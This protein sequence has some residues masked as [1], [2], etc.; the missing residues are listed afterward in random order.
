MMLAM[1]A[2][3]RPVAGQATPSPSPAG[4]SVIASGEG[5]VKRTPDRAWVQI[6]AESRARNPREA[7]K[8]NVDTMSLV[9]QK[10]RGTGLPPDA[11]QTRGYDL[12]PEF[13][14]HN[15]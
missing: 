14:Y 7:Q 10:L 1:L 5:L 12:Q 11:I 6:T 9:L 8:L 2:A 15:G 3:A 13:H 4:P